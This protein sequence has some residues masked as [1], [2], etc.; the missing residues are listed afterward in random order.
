MVTIQF[1]VAQRP[2]EAFPGFLTTSL[3]TLCRGAEEQGRDL[4]KFFPLCPSAFQAC[5]KCGFS[6]VGAGQ[7]LNRIYRVPRTDQKITMLAIGATPKDI[8]QAI[9]GVF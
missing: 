4:Y 7:L 9:A 5:E 6:L 3:K 1:R 8:A 2:Q